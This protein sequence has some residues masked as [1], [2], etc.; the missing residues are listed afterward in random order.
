MCARTFLPLAC[1][2]PA[3]TSGIAPLPFRIRKLGRT[4]CTRSQA[5][6]PGRPTARAPAG[7]GMGPCT[8]PAPAGPAPGRPAGAGPRRLDLDGGV[9]AGAPGDRHLPGLGGGA[10]W[11]PGLGPGLPGL[12]RAWPSRARRP[13]QVAGPGLAWAWPI[14][15]LASRGVTQATST[16]QGLAS[17]A[18]VVASLAWLP[19]PGALV[20]RLGLALVWLP[21]WSH[22]ATPG[23]AEAPDAG[24]RA[25][26]RIGGSRGPPVA[27]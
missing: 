10:A 4:R 1:G 11:P 25:L 19:W 17:L 13:G 15:R 5:G 16:T 26:S 23:K 21:A 2:A 24:K 9:Q 3:A 22:H 7:P 27:S 12:P 18:W 14:T 6:R 8:R 20:P